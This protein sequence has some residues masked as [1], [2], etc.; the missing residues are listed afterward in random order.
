LLDR[1]PCTWTMPLVLFAFIFLFFLVFISIVTAPIL[2][3]LT[4]YNTISGF[5]NSNVVRSSRWKV[6]SQYIPINNIN[7]GKKN[8]S[9]LGGIRFLCMCLIRAVMVAIHSCWLSSSISNSRT[10]SWILGSWCFYEE[11]RIQQ[12]RIQS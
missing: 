10:S 2:N 7:S 9:S 3:S 11:G 12:R 4:L 5:L 6:N 1:C 8:T